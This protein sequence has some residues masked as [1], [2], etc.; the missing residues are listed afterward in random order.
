MTGLGHWVGLGTNLAS[1]WQ[2]LSLANQFA[3][4]GSVVLALATLGIGWWVTGQIE[5]S[6]VRNSANASALYMDSFISPLSQNL[7]TETELSPGAHRALDE[8][9]T[10]TPL[11]ERIVS[12]KIWDLHGKVLDAMDPAIVG[13]SFPVED[14]LR[15]AINGQI[16]SGFGPLTEAENAAESALGLPLLEIYSPIRQD[17]S[18]KV[19]AVAEFYE[20]NDQL[21]DDLTAARWGAWATVSA[22]VLGLGSV[23]Y[24][25]VLGGS[26]L[27]DSQRRALDARMSEL[28][29]LSSHNTDLRLRVQG[30]AARAATQTENSMRRIGADL[31][32]G[33]AQYLAYA[34]LRLD[35]L[36]DRIT[37]PAAMTEVDSVAGAVT[38]AMTEVRALS[39]GLSLPEIAGHSL[40]DIVQRAA[41]AHAVRSGSPVMV[42]LHC[43]TEPE[44]PLAARICIFRFVQEGLNNA[45]R[46]GGGLGME[47]TLTGRA[48]TLTLVVRDHG[49]GLDAKTV[50][51]DGRGLG[52]PGLR[53]RVE[54][55]GGVFSARTHPEGGTEL[56]MTLETGA[57]S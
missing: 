54:S 43:T 41:D 8:I 28:R 52:L 50:P 1:R 20:R 14:D 37:D 38:H 33:P 31:H 9:F 13:Q 55:L 17:W 21:R 57:V 10:N 45:S 53:D 18:G 47:V 7:A 16:T 34:A 36:R 6:V 24:F 32:D 25:I 29:V 30:A 27:I 39:R 46:Y 44:V 51:Q 19:I 22:V 42:G 40:K 5:A 4:A 15:A 35:A 3:V 11:G 26:R 12:F 56:T 23:L 49:P 2:R 48:K